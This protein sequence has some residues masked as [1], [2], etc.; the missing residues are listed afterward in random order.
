MVE[1]IVYTGEELVHTVQL[2]YKILYEVLK[3]VGQTR[4]MRVG[5]QAILVSC[6]NAS[7][8][9]IMYSIIVKT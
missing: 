1:G 9:S 4:A 8:N 2:Q 7:P 5:S 6:F 3:T